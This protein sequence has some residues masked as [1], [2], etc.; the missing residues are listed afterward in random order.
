[1]KIVNDTVGYTGEYP[2]E[3]KRNLEHYIGKELFKNMYSYT[4]HFINKCPMTL[5][6]LE[7]FG[8]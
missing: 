6:S 2:E 8:F 1:M 3:A 4:W 7:F 5:S